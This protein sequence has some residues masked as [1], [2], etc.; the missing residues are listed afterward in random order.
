MIRRQKKYVDTNDMSNI[1]NMSTEN[2]MSTILYMSAAEN[3]LKTI[4]VM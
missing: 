3:D 2:D 1:F 4:L